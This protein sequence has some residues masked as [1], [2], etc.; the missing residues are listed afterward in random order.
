M[1]IWFWTKFHQTS[2]V[3]LHMYIRRT[4]FFKVFLRAYISLTKSHVYFCYNIF[5]RRDDVY[6]SFVR[7]FVREL[8]TDGFDINR[9]VTDG[10][11]VCNITK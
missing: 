1:L 2:T 4:K 7:T 3:F 5:G 9:L 11:D 6:K 10:L 8:V